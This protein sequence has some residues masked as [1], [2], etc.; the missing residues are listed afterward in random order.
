MGPL[1]PI[2]IAGGLGLLAWHRSKRKGMTPKRKKMFE[3]LVKTQKDPDTLHKAASLFSKEGLKAEAAVLTKRAKLFGA[4][5][6]VKAQRKEVFQKAMSSKNPNIVQKAIKAFHDMGHFEAANTL[7][8]Y[9][10]G[11]SGSVKIGEEE[12][13]SVAEV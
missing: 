2:G 11:L 5:P 13:G 8:R 12:R 9:G 6:E 4:S 7:R 1:I 3:A 10:A